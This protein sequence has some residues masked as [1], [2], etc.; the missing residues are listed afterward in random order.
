[1]YPDQRSR[2]AKLA[3]HLEQWMSQG[4][5]KRETP[6]LSTSDLEALRALGYME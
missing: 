3:K 2:A 6:N 4:L 5:Q 1:V